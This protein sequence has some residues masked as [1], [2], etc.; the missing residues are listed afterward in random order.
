MDKDGSSLSTESPRDI[1][2]LSTSS[3][4]AVAAQERISQLHEKVFGNYLV[5]LLE[6]F[7]FLVL[8]H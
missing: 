4:N 6:N 8:D 5:T 1:H 3:E 7:Y 2:L